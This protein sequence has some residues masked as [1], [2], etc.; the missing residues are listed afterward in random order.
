M[1]SRIITALAISAGLALVITGVFYQVALR[2]AGSKEVPM[3]EVVTAAKDLEVGSEIQPGDPE[4]KPGR[5]VTSPT[6][7]TRISSWLLA[8]SRPA[9]F[10]LR[11]LCLIGGWLLPAPASA[12]PRRF[13]TECGPCRFALTT[14][15]AWP[16]SSCP[17]PVW[18]C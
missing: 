16:A 12:S 2:D 10:L 9:E 13:P 17:R 3:S 4:S 8:V 5:P 18:T 6:G 14:S 7:L 11:S 1:N 15:T